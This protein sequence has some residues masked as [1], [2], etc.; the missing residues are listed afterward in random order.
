MIK[1][2]SGHS[3]PVGSTV[4]LVNFCNQLN[5]R[6]YACVFYGPDNWHTDKCKSGTLTEFKPENGD[7]VIVHNIGLLSFSDLYISNSITL[8]ATRNCLPR[9]LRSIVSGLFSSTTLNNLKLFLTFPGND[10]EAKLFL[11]Y[12]LFRK[13]HFVSEAQRNFKKTKHPKFVCPD[14]LVDLKHSKHKPDRTAGII[15]SIRKEKNIEAAIEKALHD[16]METIILYGYLADPIYYYE[17]IVPLTRAH[18]G[19]IKFAGFM[20][21]QQRMYDSVSDVYSSVSKP[22]SMTIRE[23]IMTNTEYHGPE[24]T[25]SDSPTNDQIFQ[26]WKDELELQ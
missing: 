12:S 10:Q 6:G 15:G 23:C 4:A 3:Y 19:K 16:G 20:D 24:A 5:S 18:P 21:D 8:E 11:R 26:V 22:W 1:I 7:I 25:I 13:I 17:K 2:I 14:F 9:M